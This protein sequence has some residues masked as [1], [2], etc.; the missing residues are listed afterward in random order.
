MINLDGY[1]SDMIKDALKSALPKG[2]GV[3][4]DEEIIKI[5]DNGDSKYSSCITTIHTRATLASYMEGN[6]LQVMESPE[7]IDGCKGK[8]CYVMDGAYHTEY[9]KA[10]G[11]ST[12]IF[13]ATSEE[14]THKLFKVYWGG[15]NDTS[16]GF[17][18]PKEFEESLSYLKRTESSGGGKGITF[19]IIP[20]QLLN[21][22]TANFN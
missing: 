14:K 18:K 16:R 11:R 5:T 1:T 7:W 20:L 4:I 15:A 6:L 13:D 21:A 2:C 12:A 10:T 17:V 9:D 19:V 3:D 22:E 8:S